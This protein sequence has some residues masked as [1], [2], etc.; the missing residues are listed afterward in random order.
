M[1]VKSELHVYTDG[2]CSAETGGFGFVVVNPTTGQHIPVGQGPYRDTTNNQMEMMAVIAAMR[3]IHKRIGAS[4]LLIYSDS[5]YVI[6]GIT[7]WI[8]NW[9]RNGW[10]TSDRKL[11][12]NAALWKDMEAARDLHQITRFEWVRGHDG[13]K[14][15]EM[16]DQLAVYH[17]TQIA[18]ALTIARVAG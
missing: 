15:N 10:F 11:V 14:Y 5:K 16:A 17:R 18:K 8:H 3:F 9:K 6:N 4:N 12:K 2:A 7:S 13:N 1:R